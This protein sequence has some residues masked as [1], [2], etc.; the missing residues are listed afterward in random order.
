MLGFANVA[1]KPVRAGYGGQALTRKVFISSV[2]QGFEDYRRAAR[3]AVLLLR[4]EPVMAEDFEA[5]SMSPQLACLEGV[6]SSDIYMGLFGRKYSAPTKEE[7][8]EAQRLEKEIL[9]L[10]KEGSR[11]PEQEEFLRSVEDWQSGY[12]RNT[13]AD[14]QD[15]RDKVIAALHSSL[16]RLDQQAVDPAHYRIPIDR[17][18][19]GS[20]PT[21]QGSVWFGIVICPDCFAPRLISP[22]DL[23]KPGFQKEIMR[24]ALLGDIPLSDVG[25]GTE[26]QVHENTLILSQVLQ[27]QYPRILHRLLEIHTE[28][29]LVL[30][31]ILSENASPGRFLD[32]YIIDAQEVAQTL[33]CALTFAYDFYQQTKLE[34]KIQHIYFGFSLTGVSG[35]YFGHRP[36]MGVSSITIP[37]HNLE[38]PARFPQTPERR[39]LSSLANVNAVVGNMT[40]L[41]SRR[42]RSAQAYYPD[43]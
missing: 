33:R 28:G 5:R 40:E 37:D 3:E 17:Y 6:R 7:F 30:G 9:V 23:G 34:T 16:Y 10:I 24:L 32:H 29:I 26:T 8:S 41:V 39:A 11:D 12:F 38:D 21:P 15:L 36:P 19:W 18:D 31:S 20:R 27:R 22:F 25:R 1:V 4:Q 42:F 43:G 35:K 13:F 2:V 14:A